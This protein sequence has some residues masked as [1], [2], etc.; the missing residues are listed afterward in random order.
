MKHKLGNLSY[1]TLCLLVGAFAAAGNVALTVTGHPAQAL[2]SGTITV[3]GKVKVDSKP[4]TTGDTFNSSST[5]TTAKGSSAV[6]SLGK[7]GRVELL[8]SS[9]MKLSFSSSNIAAW[10]RNGRA[11]VTK[12]EGASANVSTMD[13]EIIADGTA[14][15]EFTVDVECG[16]TLVSVRSGVVD[17]HNKGKVTRI[18]AGSSNS[19][20]KPKDHCRRSNMP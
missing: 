8:P 10:L 2:A 9:S 12:A 16:D 14:A 7:L 5:A 13:G 1:V 11:I 3:T 18:E 4:A 20:G 17:L 6:V 19:V 15:S